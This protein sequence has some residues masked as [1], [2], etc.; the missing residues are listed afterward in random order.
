M[1]AIQIEIDG[2][3]GGEFS[4]LYEAVVTPETVAHVLS[5]A[6]DWSD[7]I[8]VGLAFVDDLGNIYT[9]RWDTRLPFHR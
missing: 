4:R 6:V 3:R 7:V 8:I 2:Q 9:S 5:T 1:T